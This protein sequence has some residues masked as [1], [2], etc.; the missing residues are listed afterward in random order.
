MIMMIPFKFNM[1]GK[2]G[3]PKTIQITVGNSCTEYV[4]FFMKKYF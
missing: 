3:H 4:F 1:K 2:L